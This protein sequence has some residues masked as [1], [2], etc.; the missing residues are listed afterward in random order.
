MR[1]IKLCFVKQPYNYDATWQSLRFPGSAELLDAFVFR[2]M[3]ISLLIEFE[4]DIWVV[5]GE[6][7]ASQTWKQNEPEGFAAIYAA[8]W[9]V[10]SMLEVPWE[11]Y[12]IVISIDPLIPDKIIKRH[13]NTLWAYYEIEHRCGRSSRAAGPG[14]GPYGGYDL[15]LDHYMRATR[16]LHRLPQS[17]AFPFMYNAKTMRSLVRLTHNPAVFIDTRHV[18]RG[19]DVYAGMSR[20]FA[21]ICGLPIKFAGVREKLVEET[22]Y[23]L[24]ELVA[25]KHYRAK[26][27]LEM[28]GACKF[29]LGWRKRAILGQALVEAASLGLIGV[30]NANG[31]YH[32]MIC[33]PM[34]LIPPSGIARP[35]L[36]AIW[37]IEAVPDLQK[38][39]LEYQDG[40]LR[41]RFWEQPLR[42]LRDALKI[43]RGE[44]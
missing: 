28:L 42:I 43:K 5:K 3:H 25:G 22:R 35:G 20:E 32:K 18:P 21:Q 37:G 44:L 6:G 33:H 1:N 10:V 23:Y 19:K 11:D 26:E 17:I 8:H 31:V 14:G 24:L 9:N 30:G 2:P 27:Y 7:V 40:V 4:A 12:D 16:G 36:K 29:F 41:E 39:I 38:E 15:Y 34:C 13:S